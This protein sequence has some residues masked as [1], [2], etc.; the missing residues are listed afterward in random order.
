MQNIKENGLSRRSFLKT[1][2]LGVGILAASAPSM[3]LHNTVHT[4]KGAVAT[5]TLKNAGLLE[6]AQV[7]EQYATLAN[8]LELPNMNNSKVLIVLGA[9]DSLPYPHS[10]DNKLLFASLKHLAMQGVQANDITIAYSA[11]HNLET[12]SAFFHAAQQAFGAKNNL[13]NYINTRDLKEWYSL[14]LNNALPTI[15]VLPQAAAADHILYLGQLTD[16]TGLLTTPQYVIANVLL[17]D[18]SVSQYADHLD[19]LIEL[20]AVFDA[21]YAKV[22]LIANNTTRFIAESS[23]GKRETIQ[24]HPGILNMSNSM[25]SQRIFSQSYFNA[26]MNKPTKRASI[27]SE[28]T[29][30]QHGKTRDPLTV[31]TIES[32][33]AKSGV[34]LKTIQI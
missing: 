34:E 22:S 23:T 31:Q 3:A 6:H 7:Y 15:N 12:S 28:L 17:E 21:V 14:N 27:A 26:L 13:P 11:S 5:G 16:D 24:V 19:N 33:L 2:G 30:L 20:Q 32:A 8:A 1:T 18:R 25:T 4:Q 9:V 29:W 10:V